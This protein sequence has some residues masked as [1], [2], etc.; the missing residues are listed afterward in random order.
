MRHGEAKPG[1]ATITV[2]ASDVTGRLIS[3]SKDETS[4]PRILTVEAVLT[5]TGDIEP[6]TLD[7][8]A[9][10][11]F[12]EDATARVNVPVGSGNKF[13]ANEGNPAA[14]PPTSDRLDIR[15][16]PT[17]TKI[18]I[19][20]ADVD[21][22]DLLPHNQKLNFSL[23]DGGDLEF[24]IR[25]MGLMGAAINVKSG[26]GLSPADS[27]YDFTLSVNEFG[28]APGNSQ[29][30]AIRVI[31]VSDNVPPVFGASQPTAGTVI[32]R[33]EEDV[34]ATFTGT[35]ANN[36]AVTFHIARK[37]VVA[38]EDADEAERTN[39]KDLNT[40]AENI[41]KGFDTA[42]FRTSGILKTKTK[43][44]KGDDA[45]Q[46]DFFEAPVD[47]PDTDDV[48]ESDPDYPP[49]NEHTYLVSLND[50]TLSSTKIEF[51]LT[52]TDE[53]DPLPGSSKY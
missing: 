27:P 35:D 13:V 34:V 4:D 45:D 47:N 21:G 18:G 52:V 26:S 9:D 16:G 28:N 1:T 10:D 5:P 51:T 20:A 39:I 44:A 50:G 49:V 8:E 30:L 11:A 6:F 31:V 48:D 2:K 40:N 14:T 22:D 19:V 25:K 46:P 41:L 24:Q 32:E 17:T 3:P 33:S 7:D 42:S 29:E 38:D 36:Q 12:G 43:K 53:D 37:T 15:V 23:V